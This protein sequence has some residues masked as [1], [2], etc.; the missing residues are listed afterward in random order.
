MNQRKLATVD[1]K[2]EKPSWE[3]QIKKEEGWAAN[4]DGAAKADMVEM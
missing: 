1:E 4:T 2:M 3:K